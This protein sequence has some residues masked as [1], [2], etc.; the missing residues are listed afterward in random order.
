MD[1][2][3]QVLRYPTKNCGITI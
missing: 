1:D 3:L 2:F